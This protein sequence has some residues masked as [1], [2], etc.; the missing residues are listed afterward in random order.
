MFTGKRGKRAH[1]QDIVKELKK[2]KNLNLLQSVLFVCFSVLEMTLSITDSIWF[3]K[4]I[5]FY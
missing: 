1:L 2:E 4:L 3:T 5:D